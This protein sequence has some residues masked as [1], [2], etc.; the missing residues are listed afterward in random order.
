[1]YACKKLNVENQEC[2]TI[3]VTARYNGVDSYTSLCELLFNEL[4][5]GACYIGVPGVFAIQATKRNFGIVVDIGAGYTNIVP[6][7]H[8][9][10][11][12]AN[13]KCLDIG[14]SDIN[15]AYLDYIGADKFNDLEDI[16]K[17]LEKLKI[18][19]SKVSNKIIALQKEFKVVNY[20]LSNGVEL[21]LE[22]GEYMYAPEVL[23]SPEILGNDLDKNGVSGMIHKVIQ[24]CPI[25][26]RSELY[27][28]VILTGSGSK[29]KGIGQRIRSDLRNLASK[30]KDDVR[31]LVGDEHLAYVG[32]AKVANSSDFEY[33]LVTKQDFEE[34]GESVIRERFFIG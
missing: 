15:K 9:Y 28:S 16:D 21:E 27:M 14:G 26:L 22:K 8:G 1:M 24:S 33:K 13:M 5:F 17:E 32:A 23:F 25:D 29:L 18:D 20:K 7:A 10:P 4:R 2:C 3:I 12:L 31:V 34:F 11:M 6:I 19:I 30:E